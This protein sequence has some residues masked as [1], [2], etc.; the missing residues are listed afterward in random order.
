MLFELQ[1]NFA[2][3]TTEELEKVALVSGK[4][5]ENE[6]HRK[7]PIKR[8]CPRQDLNLYPVKD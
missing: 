6:E 1:H 3:S 8:W 2:I 7:N 5:L 4:C